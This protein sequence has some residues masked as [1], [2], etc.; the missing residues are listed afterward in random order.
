MEVLEKHEVS[1]EYGHSWD[2]ASNAWMIAFRDNI[3]NDWKHLERLRE[4][5]IYRYT[6]IN[7]QRTGKPERSLEFSNKTFL[8]RLL[9]V[10]S[11]IRH[12]TSTRRRRKV[13]LTK[14][15]ARCW[16]SLEYKYTLMMLVGVFKEW[17]WS[18]HS[19]VYR[20]RLITNHV[21]K[22]Q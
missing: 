1:A 5:S 11:V 19:G 18:N 10:R 20:N 3:P 17:R 8:F 7:R 15:D 13:H 4:P 2:E 6:T 14:H 12:A 21:P 16:S 22:L 9:E